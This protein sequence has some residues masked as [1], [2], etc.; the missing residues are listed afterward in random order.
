MI[1]LRKFAA[2]DGHYVVSRIPLTGT[3]RAVFPVEFHQGGDVEHIV[4]KA[5]PAD[6][7]EFAAES[8]WCDE[9]S[10]RHCA[11]DEEWFANSHEAF[12]D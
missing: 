5:T 6:A 2:P 9:V 4:T 10:E 3:K 11:E 1:T 7:L 8:A 12:D